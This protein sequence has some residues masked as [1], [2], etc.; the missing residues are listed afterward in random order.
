MKEPPMKA[1]ENEILRYGVRALRSRH[2]EIR[3][4]KRLHQ[5]SA[6]GR[7]VWDSTWL[8]VDFLNH[9][10]YRKGIHVMELGCGWG[11][12]GIYFAKKYQAAVTGIDIDIE[13]F[14]YLQVH[15]D[16]NEVQIHTKRIGF[17]QLIGTDFKDIDIIIGSDICFWNRMSDVLQKTLCTAMNGGVE[18]IL[19]ADPGRPPFHQL[20][21]YFIKT[22]EGEI[23]NWEVQYP[24]PI[25]GRI[26]KI[27]CRT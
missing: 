25:Q 5:P 13:V 12:A 4:L 17:D 14:P 7:R 26:L 20:G 18:N 21:E 9:R 16:L 23:L 10:E 19:I 11:L 1:S 27:G 3:K 2:R 15:A 6:H 24:Y 8:L 22:A